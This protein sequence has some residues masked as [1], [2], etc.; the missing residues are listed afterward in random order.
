MVA[1]C[2]SLDPERELIWPG[3][4]AKSLARCVNRII[5]ASG[6]PGTTRWIRRGSSSD[7]DRLHPG[8]GWRFLAHSTPTVFENHYRVA[9][10]CDD[11]AIAPTQLTVG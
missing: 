6:L 7:V 9:S 10:I 11:G 4:N 2:I 1:A 5:R 3:H 8:Q